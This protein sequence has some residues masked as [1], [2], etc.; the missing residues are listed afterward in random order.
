MTRTAHIDR[1]VIDRLPPPE[2]LPQFRFDSP[3][4]AY[5]EKINAAAELIDRSIA[6]GR[7][8][9][10]AFHGANGAWRYAELS[11]MVNRIAHALVDNLGLTPGNRVL[12]RAVNSPMLEVS[13]T[14]N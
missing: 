9:N 12:L 4:L 11:G 6:L 13:M 1:F 3:S 8:Q 5:A 2:L 10:V 14:G 7:G